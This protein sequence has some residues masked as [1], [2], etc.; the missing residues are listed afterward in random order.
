MNICVIFISFVSSVYEVYLEEA[1][2][3]RCQREEAGGLW[4]AGA[5]GSAQPTADQETKETA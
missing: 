3:D 1:P 5:R 2:T 4:N